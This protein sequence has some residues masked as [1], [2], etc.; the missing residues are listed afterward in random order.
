[1]L[2]FSVLISILTLLPQLLFAQL[3]AE[4]APG[5]NRPE[6]VIWASLGALLLLLISIFV[7]AQG[8]SR[9]KRSRKVGPPYI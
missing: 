7:A 2:R 6:W 5:A 9:G 1:M 8:G 4:A 3:H